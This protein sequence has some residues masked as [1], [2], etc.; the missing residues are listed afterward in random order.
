MAQSK[1]AQHAVLVCLGVHIVYQQATAF[2]CVRK[3]IRL[4]RVIKIM[5][6]IRIFRVIR[7][8]L[9]YSDDIDLTAL[10]STGSYGDY[11]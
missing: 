7:V 9:G 3:I 1:R 6:A 11:Q 5:R 10:R 2:I 4:S 8:M